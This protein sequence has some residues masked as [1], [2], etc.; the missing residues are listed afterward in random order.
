MD[1]P[2]KPKFFTFVEGD[3]AEPADVPERVRV[4]V[5]LMFLHGAKAEHLARV[6]KMPEEWVDDFAHGIEPTW[7][8]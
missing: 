8:H 3:Y 7:L 2:E 4:Y 5:R 1:K 6:F